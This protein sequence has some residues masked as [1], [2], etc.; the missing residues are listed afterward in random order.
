MKTV[1]GSASVLLRRISTSNTPS[2]ELLAVE[3]ALRPPLGHFTRQAA[4]TH[5]QPSLVRLSKAF[6]Q[7]VVIELAEFLEFRQLRDLPI[8]P[9]RQELPPEDLGPL[10]REIVI[11]VGPDNERFESVRSRN[12]APRD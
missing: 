11:R 10:G 9:A 7:C 6:H 5:R 3:L 4:L 12:F 1:A 8:D 2:R